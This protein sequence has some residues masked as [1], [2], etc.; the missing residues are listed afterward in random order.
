MNSDGVDAELTDG[1]AS[2][3]V[4]AAA[5]LMDAIGCDAIVTAGVDA[6]GAGGEINGD[7]DGDSDG[8]TVSSAP[9]PDEFFGSSKTENGFDV[10]IGLTSLNE[11]T[12]CSCHHSGPVRLALYSSSTN[13]SPCIR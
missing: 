13:L 5:M 10:S 3:L 2:E 8:M 11:T 12:S 9:M 6:A 7:G 1:D 4:D